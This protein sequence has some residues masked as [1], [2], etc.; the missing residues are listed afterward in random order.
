MV[1]SRLHQAIESPPI[2]VIS[3]DVGKGIDSD[4]TEV[5]KN[6]VEP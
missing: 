4:V 1:F 2:L 3:T 5:F 6:G